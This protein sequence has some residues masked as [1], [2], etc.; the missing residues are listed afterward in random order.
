MATVGHGGCAVT[1][2]DASHGL[3]ARGCYACHMIIILLSMAQATT[4]AHI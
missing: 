1:R 3:H 4:I 2:R